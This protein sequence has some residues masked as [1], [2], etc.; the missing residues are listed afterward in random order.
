MKTAMQ[1]VYSN[2]PSL[3][4][5]KSL[6][7]F[8]T[9]NERKKHKK[10]N[11]KNISD[12]RIHNDVVIGNGGYSTIKLATNPK[13]DEK[14]AV[15]IIDY[16]ELAPKQVLRIEREIEVMT[17]LQKNSK[18][19]KYFCILR[20]SSNVPQEEE[21]YLYMDLIN[22]KNLF[23]TYFSEKRGRGG[24]SEDVV[25]PIFRKVFQAVAQLHSQ[26]IYHGDLKLENIILDDENEVKLVDFGFS[27]YT[28]CE[29]SFEPLLHT[30][31][32]GTVQY[33]APEILRNIPY[34]G[35]QSDMWSLGI[36]LFTMLTAKFP[37]PGCT[38]SAVLRHLKSP[39]YLQTMF[40]TKDLSDSAKSLL[41][42]LLQ[43]D[44]SQRMTIEEALNHPWFHE[45]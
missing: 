6:L 32:V 13:T 20:Y 16:S 26:H 2:F 35:A 36:S 43:V 8:E 19:H 44:P 28:R 9:E 31:Y 33:A 1:M 22:G 27:N 4:K 11:K 7:S 42:S 21:F 23:D 29:T 10:I 38:S 5:L 18:N 14:L 17:K 34:D 45:M 15:K 3:Q 25:K 37:F 41:A 40:A 39:T 12:Y 24:Y 30:D